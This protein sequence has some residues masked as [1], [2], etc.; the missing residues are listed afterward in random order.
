[1]NKLKAPGL[2]SVL[3]L[4]DCLV[5]W[6]G[7]G[8]FVGLDG[9]EHSASVYYAYRFDAAVHSSCGTYAVIYERFGTKGLVLKDGRGLR[10]I[11]RSYYHAH[12]YEYPVAI[13]QSSD[14]SSIVLK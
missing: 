4:E 1:M 13:F 12:V 5:D 8:R 3:W 2:R 10:E 6:V 9:S 11:N 7:G 14:W